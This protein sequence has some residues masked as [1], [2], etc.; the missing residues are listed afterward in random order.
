MKVL[1]TGATGFIGS[2][3][4]DLLQDYDADIYC[5]ARS[6]SN[7]QWLEGKPFSIINASL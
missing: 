6:T 5:I 2:H 4:A 3:T 1:V 7:M